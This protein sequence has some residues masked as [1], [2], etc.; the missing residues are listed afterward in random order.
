MLSAAQDA[1]K[2][3][4]RKALDRASGLTIGKR[5][6]AAW[7][8]ATAQHMMTMPLESHANATTVMFFWRNNA[9]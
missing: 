5:R 4:V 6:A 1:W 3:S 7:R 2:V 9:C 8:T